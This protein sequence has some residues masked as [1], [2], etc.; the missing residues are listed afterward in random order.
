MDAYDLE[1]A[2]KEIVSAAFAASGQRC[3]AISRVLTSRAEATKLTEIIVD[4][5][6]KLKVGNGL[7]PEVEVGPL[8]SQAQLEIVEGYIE[9]AKKEGAR[10]LTGGKRLPELGK[11]FYYSP[12]V[13]D[14]VTPKSVVAKEEVFGPVL[15]IIAVD[16]MEEALTICNDTEYGLAACVFTKDIDKAMQFATEIKTGMVHINHGTASQAHVP[17]GG[18]KN[19]GQGAYS[20][21]GTAKDFCMVNKVVYL[22]FNQ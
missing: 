22:K 17:F 10:V 18:V 7:S 14:K 5:A 3:T 15:P 19:S 21:G 13:L 11:G 8:V 12:T 2:A 9:T 4:L 1:E 20:I 6:S 16:S